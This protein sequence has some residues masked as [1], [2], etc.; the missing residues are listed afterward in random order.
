M[1][2]LGV[3]SRKMGPQRCPYPIPQ[4]LG[5]CNFIWQKGH[6]FAVGIKGANQLT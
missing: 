2:S 5:M 3:I 1:A 6:K 4:D